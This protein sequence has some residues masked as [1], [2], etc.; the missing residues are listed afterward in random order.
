[1]RHIARAMLLLAFVLGSTPAMAL[2][3]YC[4]ADLYGGDCNVFADYREE[5]DTT[6]WNLSCNEG[7][8][9]FGE[10]QGNQVEYVC[11]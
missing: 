8:F 11:Y 2:P 9:V 3:P 5:V 1:M 4:W 7:T 10:L 6:Y